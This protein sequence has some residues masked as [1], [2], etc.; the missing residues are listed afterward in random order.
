VECVCGGVAE[1]G[2]VEDD[3]SDGGGERGFER[4]GDAGEI[5]VGV[6]GVVGA[7][8]SV[9]TVVVEMLRA[10]GSGGG[11]AAFGWVGGYA[12]DGETAEK[13]VGGGGE[14][15]GVTWFEG[16]ELGC[17]VELAEGG[18]E[19]VG[20]GLVEGQGGWELDEEGA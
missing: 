8:G 3:P 7:W 17:G 18:E 10:A 6:R 11:G 15:G 1:G 9:E 4:G 14:P 5:G 2:V 12:G 13:T 20:E 19:V 16:G